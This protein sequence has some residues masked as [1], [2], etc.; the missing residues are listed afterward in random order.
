MSVNL[1]KNYV[2][3]SRDSYSQ[4]ADP[5]A[6]K[7]SGYPPGQSVYPPGP[8]CLP[9]WPNLFTHLANLLAFPAYSRGG[10]SRTRG[11]HVH[12]RGVSI[13]YNDYFAHS[14]IL[15]SL[16]HF[17]FFSLHVLYH[18]NI[19]N[20]NISFETFAPNRNAQKA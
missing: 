11:K 8:T 16:S 1:R 10:V 19:Q 20:R 12:H 3:G 4:P 7:L 17:F 5:S 2:N 13:F 9:T 14:F 15:L 6:Y 18:N